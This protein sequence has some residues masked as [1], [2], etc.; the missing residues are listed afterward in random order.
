MVPVDLNERVNEWFGNF[1][2]HAER[3]RKKK[4]TYL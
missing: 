1:T 4:Q 2:S 3:K